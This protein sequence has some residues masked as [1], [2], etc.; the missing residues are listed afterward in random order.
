MKLIKTALI[1][2]AFVFAA[3]CASQ[4]PA[5]AP[6]EPVATTAPA[7]MDAGVKHKKHG[8]RHHKDKLGQASYQKDTAK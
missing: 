6:Q 7:D 8:K 4:K 5:P 1:A 2:T 3:G